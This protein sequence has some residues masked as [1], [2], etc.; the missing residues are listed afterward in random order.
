MLIISIY[1]LGHFI[2]TVSRKPRSPD[3]LFLNGWSSQ[4]MYQRPKS[5]WLFVSVSKALPS[6][7]CKNPLSLFF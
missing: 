6:C 5:N 7:G 2:I 1:K 3:G 4:H